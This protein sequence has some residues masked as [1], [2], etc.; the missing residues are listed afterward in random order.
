MSIVVSET[1]P[2][3]LL[4]SVLELSYTLNLMATDTSSDAVTPG[5]GG[6]GF[7]LKEVEKVLL[8]I[9][10]D[11]DIPYESDDT[12][13]M[14]PLMMRLRNHIDSTS[15]VLTGNSVPFS[16]PDTTTLHELIDSIGILNASVSV[17]EERMMCIIQ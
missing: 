1:S 16:N 13:A 8:Q 7:V 17:K 9:R 4:D 6:P 5:R 12:V 10:A 2:R 11:L 15:G 14:V 3:A